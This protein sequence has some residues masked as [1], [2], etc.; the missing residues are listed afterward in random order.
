MLLE[1]FIGKRPTDAMFEGE[2][3]IR[4]W[5]HQAFPSQLDSVMDNQLL[6]DAILQP[7]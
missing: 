6:Q 1:V 2:L 3:S 7:S 4:Q 5:V